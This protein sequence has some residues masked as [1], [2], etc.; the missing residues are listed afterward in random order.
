[1]RILVTI[2]PTMYRETLALSL[3]RHRPHVEVMLASSDALDREVGRFEPHLV[4][5]NEAT[6][7][8]RESVPSWVMIMY[9]DSLNAK[10]SIGGRESEVEDIKIGNLLAVLDEMEKDP[11]LRG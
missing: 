11:A 1:M 8:V 6:P 10:V 2:A 4:V 7:K 5:C 9:D 3:H